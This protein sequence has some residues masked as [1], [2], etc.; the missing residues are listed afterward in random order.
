MVSATVE[1]KKWG[2]SLGVIIPKETIKKL[3]LDAGEK[4]H[5]EI[6]PKR[7]ISGFGMTKGGK[8]FKR[9]LIEREY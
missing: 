3:K 6:V 7:R 8:P 1:I 5:L 4:V 2:N 9:E